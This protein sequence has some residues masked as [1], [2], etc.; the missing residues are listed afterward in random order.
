MNRWQWR[1]SAVVCMLLVLG[2]NLLA[3]PMCKKALSEDD[4]LPA[5]Y[6]TSI[7]FMLGAIG[8][9]AGSVGVLLY[10]ISKAEQLALQNEGYQHL[11]VNAATQAASQANPW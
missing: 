5:A 1:I 7:L 9:V 6:M 8:T 2:N 4:A 3:C 11:F 10:R